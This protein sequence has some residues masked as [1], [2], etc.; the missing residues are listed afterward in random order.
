[1]TEYNK[2]HLDNCVD[3]YVKLIQEYSSN[4]QETINAIS[5]LLQD[6][7]NALHIMINFHDIDYYLSN[8]NP[9]DKI[10]IYWHFFNENIYQHIYNSAVNH[11]NDIFAKY[12]FNSALIV[13]LV[14]YN[15]VNI[16]N[17]ALVNNTIDIDDI[18]LKESISQTINDKYKDTKKVIQILYDWIKSYFT[19]L[20]IQDVDQLLVINNIN[21]INK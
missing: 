14:K 7:C 8:V 21:F 9:I 18:L 10:D 13:E 11:E 5:I 20:D 1:M 19:D 16:L 3:E 17:N 15:L 12:Y 6:P 2:E 4:K